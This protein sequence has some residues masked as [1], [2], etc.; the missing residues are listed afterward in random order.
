MTTNTPPVEVTALLPCPFCGAQPQSKGV[1]IR[2]GETISCRN[3][4]CM[5]GVAAFHPDA[6]A[7]C[8][9]RWNTR[10]PEAITAD[11]VRELTE[12]LERIA[13]FDDISASDYLALTGSY[14]MF[15]EPAAVKFARATLAKAPVDANP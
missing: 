10:T 6:A 9:T 1:A 5:A 12:A 11:R 7:K 13:A 14:A 8:R 4:N 15:D 3:L 2:D